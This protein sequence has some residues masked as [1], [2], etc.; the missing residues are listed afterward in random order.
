VRKTGT[1]D[2]HLRRP[3]APLQPS[4]HLPPLALP[5]RT[6]FPDALSVLFV[7]RSTFK[8]ISLDGGRGGVI[9][10]WSSVSCSSELCDA[11][12]S[13]VVISDS[14]FFNCRCVNLGCCLPRGPALSS[15]PPLTP[16]PHSPRAKHCAQILVS[17]LPSAWSYQCPGAQW[18]RGCTV[19]AGRYLGPAGLQPHRMCIHPLWRRHCCGGPVPG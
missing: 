18:Q 13:H 4:P 8:D 7:T 16:P 17:R 3:C 14:L 11:L 9:G 10:S 15:E 6:P 12:L 2:T 19:P 1:G 5:L